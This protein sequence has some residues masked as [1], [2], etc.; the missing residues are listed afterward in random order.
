MEIIAFSFQEV[1][2]AKLVCGLVYSYTICLLWI[3]KK[4]SNYVLIISYNLWRKS[5]RKILLLILCDEHKE[6]LLL[7]KLIN[8]A[9]ME[10]H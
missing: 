10:W 9:L 6:V 7:L 1:V 5:N 2:F 3:R 4:E 8:K